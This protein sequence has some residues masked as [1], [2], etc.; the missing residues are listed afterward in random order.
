MA[1]LQKYD[2]I[3]ERDKFSVDF[4]NVISFAVAIWESATQL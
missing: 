1:P 3:F 2:V 4:K